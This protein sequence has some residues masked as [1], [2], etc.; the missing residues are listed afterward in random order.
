M[1]S[2]YKTVKNGKPIWLHRGDNHY[3]DCAKMQCGAATMLGILPD[4][5]ETVSS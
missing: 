2:E 5:I 4:E 1:A 3:F